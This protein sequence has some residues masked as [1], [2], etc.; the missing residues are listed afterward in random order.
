MLERREGSG[1][2]VLYEENG[3]KNR[4]G[5]YKDKAGSNNLVLSI[6]P[7]LCSVPNAT[8]TL[9]SFI[10]AS[11]ILNYFKLCHAFSWFTKQPIG[12]NTLGTTVQNLCQKVGISGKSNHSLRA[13]GATRLFA[14]NVP[15]TREDWP[16]KH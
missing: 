6:T 16:Q 3:S 10:S 11:W 13:I 9:L 15:D 14:A 4:S 8:F 7:K 1:E 5:S 2:F 12:R